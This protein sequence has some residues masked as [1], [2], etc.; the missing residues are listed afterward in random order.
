MNLDIGNIFGQGFARMTALEECE[1][2]WKRLRKNPKFSDEEFWRAASS[3]YDLLIP[4]LDEEFVPKELMGIYTLLHDFA[5]DP[6]VVERSPIWAGIAEAISGIASYSIVEIPIQ[7]ARSVRAFY[8]DK[9][10]IVNLDT[11]EIIED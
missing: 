3:A 2:E 4:C 6:N 11:K 9:E 1:N 8:E 7:N 5:S 10:Y